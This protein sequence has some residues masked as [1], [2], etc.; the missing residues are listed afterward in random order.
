MSDLR[1]LCSHPMY[2]P[3]IEHIAFTGGLGLREAPIGDAQGTIDPLELVRQRGARDFAAKLIEDLGW[4]IT[5]VPPTAEPAPRQT[6]A[7]SDG[8]DFGER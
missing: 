1:K 3:L 4:T 8:G 6:Q 7:D 5:L 2:R